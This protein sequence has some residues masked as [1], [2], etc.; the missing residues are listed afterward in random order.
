MCVSLISPEHSDGIISQSVGGKTEIE[1]EKLTNR[2]GSCVRTFSS[3]LGHTR[4]KREKAASTE[5]LACVQMC[6][7]CVTSSCGR[8]EMSEGN[9][10]SKRADL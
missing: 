3:H 10:A 2:G 4:R 1:E 7:E 9:V 6:H 5:L 8:G